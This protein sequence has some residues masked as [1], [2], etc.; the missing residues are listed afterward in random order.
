VGK[1]EAKF[2]ERKRMQ[3]GR[4]QDPKESKL[5]EKIKLYKRGL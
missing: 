1:A 3:V 5:M 4:T 2:L